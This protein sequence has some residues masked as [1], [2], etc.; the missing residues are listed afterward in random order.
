M[1]EPAPRPFPIHRLRSFHVGLALHGLLAVA[2]C[3]VPLFDGLGFERAFASGL[4]AAPIAAALGI[5]AVRW[6]R[7]EGGGD[8]WRLFAV[9]VLAGLAL[10]VPTAICGALVEQLRQPCSPGE[11][12][13]FLVLGAGAAV[14]FGAGLGVSTAT[15]TTRRGLPGL[16]T[17]AVLL[18]ELGR[19]LHRLYWEPQVFAYSL[20]FGYWPGSLY[21]ED[22]S[23]GDALQAHRALTALLGLALV[24][25]ARAT[26]ER[27]SLLA[28]RAAPRLGSSLVA[29]LALSAAWGLARDGERLGFDLDRGSVDAALSRRVVLDDRLELHLDPGASA[30]RVEAFVI[31]A[32][33][34]YQQLE[35][36]FGRRPDGP[37]R[38]YAFRDVA[39]KKRLMGA[40]RTQI[41]R[42]WIREIHVHGLQAPHGVLHHEL[43]HVFAAELARGPFKVPTAAGLIP[44]LGIIEGVAVA[45]EWPVRQLTVHGWV[46]AMRALQLA[47]DPRVLLYPDGFWAISSSRAYTVAGSFVRWLIDTHGIEAFG[48]LYSSNDFFQAYGRRLEDLA[49]EWEVFIDA[50]PLDSAALS[51]A[52]HRFRRPG[53]FGKACPHTTANLE[54]EG[55]QA[56]GA[57][58]LAAAAQ[59]LTRVADYQPGSVEPFLAL[60]RA[61]ARRGEAEPARAWAERALRREHTT[62]EGR[63]RAREALADLD[64]RLGAAEAARTGYAE[65]RAVTT[66]AGALRLLQV[67]TAALE[68]PPEL[69]VVLR[70]W[71]LGDLSESIALVRLTEAVRRWPTDALAPYLAGRVLERVGAWPESVAATQAALDRGLPS[72]E[73]VLE[74]RRTLGR[75][76]LHTDAEAA[77]RGFEALA[78]EAPDEAARLE[79][80]DWAARARLVFTRTSTVE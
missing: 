54:T 68:R 70:G 26:T 31:E 41:A 60:A 65:V 1:F 61:H 58:D 23:V 39:Q 11:G 42:P 64:W 50:V 47:P 15:L 49:A 74:A 69:Q 8:P 37:I 10:L 21:D 29:A 18:A 77:R 48:R 79:A 53:I 28:L 66:E 22:V 38:V 71:L 5:G 30:A 52:E 73:L 3:F 7:R 67:K 72:P 12:L 20:P 13:R 9:T 76:L 43:A 24:L 27:R 59:A 75:V 33:L 36:F 16:L 2:L 34:R 6:A 46:R 14:V 40:S 19:A 17:A 57:G 80:E 56:L 63:A 45:A 35:R 78:G 51:V 4:P 32:E 25:V 55:Y 44:N 62:A